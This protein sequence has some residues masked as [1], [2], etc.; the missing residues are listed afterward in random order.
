MIIAADTL[1][2][3]GSMARFRDVPRLLKVNKNIILGAGGD[4]GDY[5]YLKDIIQQKIINEECLD[6]GFTLQPKALYSWLTRVLYNRRSKFDPFW[7]NFV[8]AGF[9]GTEPFIGTVDKLGTAYVD[10]CIAT[11]FGAYLA[12]PILRE[13]IHSKKGEKFTQEEALKLIDHCMEVLFYRDTRS[14]AKF[15]VAILRSDKDI[16]IERREVAQ[17]WNLANLIN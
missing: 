8:I 9:E 7:V 4:Y 5:Q 6:D 1:G 14:F 15:D 10:D 16:T 11:G 17:N 3:Y 12:T 2:S 13:A